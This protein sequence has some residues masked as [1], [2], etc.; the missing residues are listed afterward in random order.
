M[1]SLPHGVTQALTACLARTLTVRVHE[2]NKELDHLV[3]GLLLAEVVQR[4]EELPPLYHC[5]LSRPRARTSPNRILIWSGDASQ[6]DLTLS[7]ALSG[8]PVIA[9]MLR[10]PRVACEAKQDAEGARLRR[11]SR[12]LSSLCYDCASCEYVEVI[13]LSSCKSLKDCPCTG[14]PI[15]IGSMSGCSRLN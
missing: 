14:E 1:P 10:G 5:A 9:A 7:T 11:G 4:H 8:T 2:A 15:S 3:R 6:P 13:C 12:R